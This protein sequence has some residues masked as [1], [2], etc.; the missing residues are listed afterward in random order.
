ME[1]TPFSQLTFDD[2]AL[3]KTEVDCLEKLKDWIEKDEK[4]SKFPKL[5][6]NV[7]ILRFAIA[8]K[9]DFQQTS[10]MIKEN[11]LWRE[12]L[13]LDSMKLE[14]IVPVRGYQSVP[15]NNAMH[16]QH[17]QLLS[18][19]VGASIHKFSKDGQPVVYLHAGWVDCGSFSKTF[20]TE[21]VKEIGTEFV[22]FATRVL[23]PEGLQRPN[24]NKHNTTVIIVMDLSNLG[25]R[26]FDMPTLM[27]LKAFFE[28]VL[29]NYP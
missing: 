16:N 20:S 2:R 14:N 5:F 6:H 19:S 12:S 24:A 26:Q 28:I 18:K 1:E 4:L 3:T 7:D 10:T 11:V 15:D 27:S 23:I 29:K 9:F 17:G 8:R 13:K 25:L 21:A 22:E